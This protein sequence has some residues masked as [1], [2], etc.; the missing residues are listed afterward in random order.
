MKEMVVPIKGMHCRACEITLE[1]QISKLPGVQKATISLKSKTATIQANSLPSEAM[2]KNTIQ[3]FGYDIGYDKKPL[4]SRNP[5]DYENIL[6]GIA[7]IIAIAAALSIFDISTSNMLGTANNSGG[8][9]ALVIGITAGLS[10]CMALV[11]GLVLGLSARHAEQYPTATRMQKF[12][13]HI[14]FNTSR[15][16]SFTLLGA[17]IGSAGSFLSLTGP[18]LGTLTIVVGIVML[19]LGLQ[20]TGIFPRLSNGGFVLPPSIAKLLGI[21]QRREKEYSHKNAVVLGALSFFLPCGFTQAMQLYAISTGS[22]LQGAI[23][24][25]LFA[26]GTAPGL[27][28]IGGLTSIIK[29]NSAKRFFK[30][31]GVGVVAMAILNITNGYNLTGWQ[32]PFAKSAQPTAQNS[33]EK[34]PPQYSPSPLTKDADQSPQKVAGAIPEDH[35]LR[36]D[37]WIKSDM[38]PSTFTVKVNEAYELRLNAKE[39]GIGCMSTVMIPGLNNSPQYI[40][41]GKTNVLTFKAKRP[42]TY[43][44]TCAM[45]VPRGTITVI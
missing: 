24:M 15:V 1:D 39:D 11:G 10:T 37:F 41:G 19:L 44:I 14:F 25:G 20:L 34:E 4:I 21:K 27:L 29:G 43:Q 3:S 45:G 33:I 36:A 28:G 8:L 38:S 6:F 13:P 12:R 30:V 9:L 7:L 22:A 35:I 32:K 16:V 26:V 17:V 2:I 31:I 18:L 5:K 42:G 23:I 40:K